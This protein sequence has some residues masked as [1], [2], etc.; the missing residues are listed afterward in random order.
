MRLTIHT[1]LFRTISA[2]VLVAGAFLFATSFHSSYISANSSL[3]SATLVADGGAPP[4]PPHQ[5]TPNLAMLPV[6]HE[7]PLVADGG[8]PPPPPHQPVPTSKKA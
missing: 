8:A 4:P 3:R 5:P 6:S 1:G 2:L 7:A